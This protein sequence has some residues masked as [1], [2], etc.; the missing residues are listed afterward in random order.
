VKSQTD[1]KSQHSQHPQQAMVAVLCLLLK[2][3][4]SKMMW[5]G[6]EEF[7]SVSAKSAH[8]HSTAHSE[9]AQTLRSPELGLDPFHQHMCFVILHKLLSTVVLKL[10]FF[11]ENGRN[12]AVCIQTVQDDACATKGLAGEVTQALGGAQK[13]VSWI[14]DIGRLE[15]DFCFWL[16]LCPD[17]FPLEGRNCFSGAHS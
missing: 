16:W 13:I 4:S 15:I 5:Q 10:K 8:A 14:P 7:R 11:L 9:K 3:D 1:Y 2:S 12:I 6:W 17:I